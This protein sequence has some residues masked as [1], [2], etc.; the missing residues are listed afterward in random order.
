[1][2]DLRSLGIRVDAGRRDAMAVVQGSGGSSK[3]GCGNVGGADVGV[4]VGEKMLRIGVGTGATIGTEMEIG[5]FSPFASRNTA[6]IATDNQKDVR[7][8]F[9]AP[10]KMQCDSVCIPC[11]HPIVI[12]LKVTFICANTIPPWPPPE[13]VLQQRRFVCIFGSIEQKGRRAIDFSNG[14]ISREKFPNKYWSLFQR[15]EEIEADTLYNLLKDIG[16]LV[17]I[18]LGLQVDLEALRMEKLEAAKKKTMNIERFLS[19]KRNRPCDLLD[20]I[21]A[22]FP[23]EKS[24]LGVTFFCCPLQSTIVLNTI[25]SFG[26]RDWREKRSCTP[27]L[28]FD[29]ITLEFWE[30]KGSVTVGYPYLDNKKVKKALKS[31]RLMGNKECQC[32]DPTPRCLLPLPQGYKIPV[33]W[34][35]SRDMIWCDN[36]P[37]P[38]LFEYKEQ[39]QVRKFP[40]YFIFL[41]GGTQFRAVKNHSKFIGKTLPSTI[42]WGKQSR[43]ILDIECVVASLGGYLLGQDVLTMSFAPRDEHEAQIPVILF[44]SVMQRLIFPDN[45]YELIHCAQCKDP[46]G[47]GIAKLRQSFCG[48]FYMLSSIGKVAYKLAPLLAARIYS[49]FYVLQLQ[50]CLDTLPQSTIQNIIRYLSRQVALASREANVQPAGANTLPR[51]DEYAH[52]HIL[53]SRVPE[54]GM[55]KRPEVYNKGKLFNHGSNFLKS[56]SREMKKGGSMI[57]FCLGRTSIVL[58]N[59]G[60]AGLLLENHFQGTCGNQIV[61]YMSPCPE[62]GVDPN[63]NEFVIITRNSPESLD[64]SSLIVGKIIDGMDVVERIA[65]VK[66]EQENTS[67]PHSTV[68]ILVVEIWGEWEYFPGIR[69]C[70]M[71]LSIGSSTSL[72]IASTSTLSST[73]TSSEP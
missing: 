27:F 52:E 4:V 40:D 59:Q 25:I 58:S 71:H 26:L 16:V 66:T 13:R 30:I 44:V 41:G 18:R 28:R 45:V 56:S 31:K 65:S 54:M 62:L 49:M 23:Q 1:M 33:T 21:V 6:R 68:A 42:G 34:L 72:L 67:A 53:L 47:L 19:S 12:Y 73:T 60:G 24:V 48:P 7:S 14:S 64:A 3:I 70:C 39:D 29:L 5:C 37:F 61:V 55:N 50:K 9:E 51:C 22:L 17:R 36:V 32:S 2:V 35:K 69:R 46:W 38:K 63:G 20:P 57:F 11:P 15:P 10:I 43:V 8:E